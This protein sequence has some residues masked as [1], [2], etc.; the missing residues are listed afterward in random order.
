MSAIAG[1]LAMD[2][3]PV[4]QDQ[5]DRLVAAAPVRGLDGC[6]TW[7][8]DNYGTLRQ[9][10]ATTPEAVGERQP[11]V[12]QSG[13]TV[14]FDGRLDNRGEL[15]RALGP[16]GAALA[17]VP[18]G[19]IVL[20][21]YERFGRDFVQQ[22]AGDFAIAICHP[23]QR[24][25]A[26]F[27]SPLN[28]RPL[29]WTRAG[30][31]VAFATDI[32]TLVL[33]LGLERRLNEG[34][35]AEYMCGVMMSPTDTFLAGVQRVE[36]GSAVFFEGDRTEF[37]LWHDGPFED[38]T[39][40]SMEEHAEE[41]NALFDQAITA[42]FRSQGVVSAQLSGGLDSSSVVCRAIELY[43]AGKLDQ[44]VRAISA[45]F[46]GLPH[47]E[48]RWSSAVEDHIGI[49]AEVATSKP[50]SLAQAQQWTRETWHLPLR[51][52]AL[53]TMGGV[54]EI[55]QA[56]GRRVLL[57]G[58]GGDDWLNGSLA[59]LP[60]LLRRG[61][62]GALGEFG[63]TYFP[64]DMLPVQWA[65]SL[66][67]AG[68]PLLLPS[69]RR[70]ILHPAVRWDR[71]A[72][73]WLRSEWMDQ[74]N[75]A[76]RLQGPPSRPGLQGFAHRSRYTT[77]A[78]SALQMLGAP[79]MAY[80]ERHGIEIRHPFHDARLTRFCMAASGNHLRDRN[81]RKRILREAMRGTL[82]EVVRTRPD[83]AAFYFHTISA[84]KEITAARPIRDL[85]PA[86]MGWIDADRLEA[87][88]APVRAWDLS[89]KREDLPTAPYG[90][91]WF[92]LA[93]DMWLDQA[94]GSTS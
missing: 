23:R 13:A 1:V 61:Q 25:L 27:T 59:H 46:P 79:A 57:G 33:G 15:L 20:A 45:R 66:V 49:R 24:R 63:R 67:L 58:E 87:L 82:P 21:L 8:S 93:A 44:Q 90:P 84:M 39:G 34:A 55:M 47:D 4:A 2:G 69:Y 7:C 91:I 53:D 42:T 85:L 92:I 12:G 68:R 16:S 6:Q 52:S 30:G 78:N 14:L 64:H 73:P 22:L 51:P 43:R 74:V 28:W 80:V 31:L 71:S 50:F 37:W 40:R 62:F 38:W 75:L 88:F 70:D 65:K 3:R 18:D 76:D 5:L 9:A 56:S 81:F 35:F 77:Y 54:V 11:F 86:K 48:T 29:H 32:R 10:N 83:K 36:Q 72:A 26:L 17:A 41:F 94:F 60:D 19:E 89:G